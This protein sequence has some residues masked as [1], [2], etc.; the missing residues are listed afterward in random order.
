M[1]VT[2]AGVCAA[3]GGSAVI[4]LT[5][6]V[7]TSA[8][9]FDSQDRLVRTLWSGE[10]RPRGPVRI[11]WD[12]LD[13]EGHGVTQGSYVARLLTHNVQYRWQGVIGN[14]SADQIG[15]HLLRAF[16][17]IQDMAFDSAGNGFYAV[18]YN[19]RQAGLHR[20]RAA[21]PRYQDALAHADFRR[22][23]QHV[24]TDG[25]VVYFANAGRLV[26]SPPYID[27]TQTFVIGLNVTD[28]SEHLFP[29]GRVAGIHADST[30]RSAID[31]DDGTPGALGEPRSGP[32]GLAV[33]RHGS[34][35][36]VA[37]ASQGEIHV[38]DKHSGVL[39]ARIEIAGAGILAV[40]PDES[41]WVL[42]RGAAAL[43]RHF[44]A[45]A[46]EWRQVGEIG[47]L[48]DPVAL[49]VSPD[50]TVVIADAGTEQLHAFDAAGNV[51]W[52]YGRKG[53]YR[54]GGP[55]VAEDRFDFT[56]GSS[57]VAFQPDGSFWV[58]DSRNDRNLHFS[59]QRRYLDQIMY[60]PHSRVATVDTQDPT[61]VFSGFLEFKVDYSKPLAESWRLVRNWSAGLDKRYTGDDFAGL[62]TVYT[63]P[64]GRTLG[65]VRRF[66]LK[67]N[68][69]MVLDPA[70]LKPA[71]ASLGADT[72]LYEDGSLRVHLIRAGS[73]GIYSRSLQS[74]DASGEAHWGAPTLLAH[75]PVLQPDDPYYHDVPF[76]PGVNEAV[77][78]RTEQ[79]IVVSFNPG[80]SGGFHLGGIDPRREGWLWRSSPTGSWDI[81]SSGNVTPRD[82]RYEIANGVQ[83]PG[84]IAVTSGRQIIYGYHGEAWRSGEANQWLHFYD[85]GLFVGQ[86]GT[87]GLPQPTEG[88]A[89]AGLSGN[90]FAFQLVTVNGQLY[91]W[92]NDENGHGG[93]HRWW[94][95]GADGIR[96][97]E[98]PIRPW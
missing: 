13:D 97:L 57:Y 2:G 24:A 51:L 68:E 49:G 45:Q 89:V 69:V 22:V 44:S 55:E 54:Q 38:L 42:S 95:E 17:P 53:G 82:G 27:G 40:A 79:G 75:V 43:V 78:P 23:F 88:D 84:N 80:K 7:T 90:A 50:G 6:A 26:D 25:D 91:L 81:D 96:V 16:L 8:G 36:F 98:A 35:L 87:P 4:N 46:G 93:V 3:A 83:Y 31:F 73:L 32:T 15:R 62:Q 11:A 58:S 66:D 9:I 92:N 21:D 71:G 29:A 37:H 85:N 94:L 18:G 19:E 59:A 63:L 14:T 77:Y 76:V 20:F 61:R 34:A 5:Q 30:W 10:P 47:G 33:Q 41:L 1:G 60:I 12:G 67:R 65:V 39:T 70:G 28:G 52:T 64:G 74:L 72:R 86:F 56:A 48:A